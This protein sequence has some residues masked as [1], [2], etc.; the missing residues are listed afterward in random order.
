MWNWISVGGGDGF[1]TQVDP[2][3]PNIFYTESQNGNINRYNLNTGQV[4]SVRPALPGGGGRG[5]GAGGGGGGAGGGGQAA[6]AAGGQAAAAGGAPAGGA[7]A[8]A[9]GGQGGGRGRGN[10]LNAPEAG[11]IQ[12]F[13]W[14]SPIRLSPHNP[15][16]LLF[17]GRQLFVSRDRGETWV[18]SQ[19]AR[20]EHRPQRPVDSRAALLAAELRRR[21]RRRAQPESRQAVHPLEARRLR[22][23][24]VRFDHRDSPS[25]RS[26]PASSGPAPT[27][28]TCR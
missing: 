2:T 22:P 10:V 7:P 24:R 5:G 27:T 14:N 18:V 16:T 13:N 19:F 1:Q 25:R 9:G 4:Q 23:E 21:A 3:D 11:A 20:Q 8:Q 6:A 26:F 17:G 12:Q 28:A 15:S